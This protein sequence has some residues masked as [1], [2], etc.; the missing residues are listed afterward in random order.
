MASN[1]RTWTVSIQ[2]VKYAKPIV[3]IANGESADDALTE[4][5]N[6]GDYIPDMGDRVIGCVEH[7]Q[8][9]SRPS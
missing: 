4:C 8:T 6:R 2:T 5:E 3:T 1:Q 7:R 9:D